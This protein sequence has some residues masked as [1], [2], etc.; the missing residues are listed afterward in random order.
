MVDVVKTNKTLPK[1]SKSLA[2][3]VIAV[4]LLVIGFLYL[5]FTKGYFISAF[6][7]GSPIYHSSVVSELEKQAGQQ[8]LDNLIN[9]KIILQEAFNNEVTVPEEEIQTE[10]ERIKQM[11][12]SGGTDFDSFLLSQGITQE[13]LEQNI[14][15]RKLIE[16]LLADKVS[17]GD[18]EIAKYY[19]ENKTVF[20][21]ATLEEVKGDI[22]ESLVSE[23][24]QTE[25]SAWITEK[26]SSANIKVFAKFQ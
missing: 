17:V 14:F 11:V 7:N 9:E 3:K 25:F 13:T 20:G 16:K 8:V 26:R 2:I 12:V 4:F 5:L 22:E 15:I 18:E 6:V 1:V 23:K 24:L 10:V 19:E 21:T